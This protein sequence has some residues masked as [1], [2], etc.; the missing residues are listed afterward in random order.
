MY[1]FK[2]WIKRLLRQAMESFVHEIAEVDIL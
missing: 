2:E 1:A